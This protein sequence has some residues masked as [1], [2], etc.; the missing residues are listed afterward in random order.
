MKMRPAASSP[1]EEMRRFVFFESLTLPAPSSAK[2]P[3]AVVAGDVEPAPGPRAG[4]AMDVAT[5]DRAASGTV[6]VVVHGPSP[7]RAGGAGV[8]VPALALAAVP[9]VVATLARAGAGGVRSGPVDLLARALA[10]V[11]DPEVAI[12]AVEGEA[13]RVAQAPGPEVVEPA[14]AHARVARRRAIAPRPAPSGSIGSMRSSLPRRV[15]SFWLRPPG[16]RHCRHRRCRCRA[17]RPARRRG[18]RRCGSSTVG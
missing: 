2:M 13:P 15:E 14:P 11:A 6:R 10:H 1:N 5:R 12:G 9:A 18:A 16:L 17:C 8:R 4:T 3:T 7:E